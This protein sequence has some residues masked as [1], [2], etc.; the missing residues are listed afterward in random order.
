MKWE[1]RS[2]VLRLRSPLHAG[3]YRLGN[4]QHCRPY[5][6]ARAVWGALAARLRR[7]ERFPSFESSGAYLHESV[8]LSYLFPT[9]EP[10]CGPD[11]T[12]TEDIRNF[13]HRYMASYASTALRD[14][15]V[16]EDGTLRE[17]E[18]LMPMT[19]ERGGERKAVFLMGALFAK[20]GIDSLEEAFGRIRLGGERSYGWGEVRLEHWGAVRG[21]LWEEIDLDADRPRLRMRQGARLPAH[22]DLK[23]LG[24]VG[25]G[26]PYISRVTSGYGP[27]RS[28]S[29]QMVCLEPGKRNP[30]GER[31][32]RI[33]RDGIL[34]PEQEE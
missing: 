28:F 14:G 3:W 7:D 34:E 23:S 25:G 8:A 21:L 16:K 24:D 15:R 32:F 12:W 13:G 2:F 1:A 31:W 19:R 17:A 11:W 9:T 27:G 6:P 33:G 18:Y 4:V 30:L 10:E 29:S 20:E 26:V 5:V 22:V